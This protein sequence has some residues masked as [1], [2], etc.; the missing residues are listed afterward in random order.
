MGISKVL[1]VVGWDFVCI[2]LAH[3][4]IDSMHWL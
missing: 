3:S 2:G 1:E 4:E